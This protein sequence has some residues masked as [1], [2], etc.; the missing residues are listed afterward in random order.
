[1]SDWELCGR[2]GCG[3]P[4]EHRVHR[5][6]PPGPHPLPDADG[7]PHPFQPSDETLESVLSER[8]A[9][10]AYWRKR[11]YTAEHA[12]E[13]IRLRAERHKRERP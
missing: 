5:E 8:D 2:E 1:M 11:A 6:I 9:Q 7:L 13:E 3:R 12:L 4:R 10:I